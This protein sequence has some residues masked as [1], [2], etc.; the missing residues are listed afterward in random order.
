M[1]H[2]TQIIAT[3]L[4]L[5]AAARAQP[6]TAP[7]ISVTFLDPDAARAAIVDDSA[8]PYFDK[9]TAAEMSAKTPEPITGDTREEQELVAAKLM[10]R[11]SSR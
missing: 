1:Q 9:L 10:G 8:D 2:L 5:A 7:A 6:A 11:S 3:V 4:L